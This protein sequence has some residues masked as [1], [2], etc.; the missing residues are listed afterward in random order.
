[1]KSGSHVSGYPSETLIREKGKRPGFPEN[2][3]GASHLIR[4]IFCEIRCN[5]IMQD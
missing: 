2:G 1:M 5:L 3:K 4:Q